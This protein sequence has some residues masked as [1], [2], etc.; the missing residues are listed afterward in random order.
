MVIPE[1]PLQ[2]DMF[3]GDLRDTRSSA[4]KRRELEAT[5]PQQIGMFGTKQA[6]EHM[7]SKVI[8]HSGLAQNG[9][10][11]VL[12]LMTPDTR[13]EEEKEQERLK[14]AEKQ[15]QPMFA[16]SEA[17]QTAIISEPCMVFPSGFSYPLV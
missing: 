17:A 15:T 14:A 16:G 3:T 1:A 13:S 4:Q 8:P 2:Q 6:I 10:P 5:K 7:R 9:K 11:L 12:G